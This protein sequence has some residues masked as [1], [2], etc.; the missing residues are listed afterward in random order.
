MHILSRLHI[1]KTI[2]ENFKGVQHI[3]GQGLGEPQGYGL[4]W[5]YLIGLHSLS[6]DQ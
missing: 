6:V 2:L 4:A 3:L 1:M 5:N